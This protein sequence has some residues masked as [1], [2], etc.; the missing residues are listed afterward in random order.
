MPRNPIRNHKL[1]VPHETPVTNRMHES[2]SSF[3]ES[4]DRAVDRVTPRSF[5]CRGVLHSTIPG[6]QSHP[7][8]PPRY[9]QL[10]ALQV[11]VSCR[12]DCLRCQSSFPLVSSC[13][14]PHVLASKACPH[15]CSNLAITPLLPPRPA[16]SFF[17]A[18]IAAGFGTRPS[19]N[20]QLKSIGSPGF[21][22]FDAPRSSSMRIVALNR[23]RQF[24]RYGYRDRS[25]S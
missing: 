22:W 25:R 17:V 4:P 3:S 23:L 19:L 8:L 16:S 11:G 15:S 1:R 5:G 2:F 10:N 18:W 24:E 20:E 12:P 7:S 14:G 6:P 13:S 21:E 9:I